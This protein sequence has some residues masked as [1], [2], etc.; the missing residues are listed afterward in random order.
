VTPYKTNSP[1]TA[2]LNSEMMADRT[3]IA[4]TF[5]VCPNIG[6]ESLRP[7]SIRCNAASFCA[8][9]VNYEL[10]MLRRAFRLAARTRKFGLRVSRINRQFRRFVLMNPI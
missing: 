5:P 3:T 7:P 1:P 9:T 4:Q 2:P 8:G 10:A 6:F